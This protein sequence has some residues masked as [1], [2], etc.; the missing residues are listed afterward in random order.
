MLNMLSKLFICIS[1]LLSFNICVAEEAKEGISEMS[2]NTQ[3]PTL[4]IKTDKITKS[5]AEWKKI[6]AP[7]QYKVTRN[8]GAEKAFTGKYSDFH[9]KGLYVCSNCAQPLFSSEVK[10]DS[11]SGWP[12]F[13]EPLSPASIATQEDKS[14][15]SKRTEVICS[16][17]D[18]H[19]GHVFPDGPPPTGL[20]YCMNSA[21]LEFIPN[22]VLKAE[23]P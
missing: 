6:L 10:Y 9:E 14:L 3:G 16:H 1:L 23:A 5:N 2:E 20:R 22:A 8:K 4:E 12:S 11:G 18:A 19:L 15:F 21:S 17:C 7:E 13:W